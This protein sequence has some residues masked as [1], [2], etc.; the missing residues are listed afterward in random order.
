MAATV[1]EFPLPPREILARN[2]ETRVGKSP[3]LEVISYQ[4]DSPIESLMQSSDLDLLSRRAADELERYIRSPWYS[5]GDE[6]RLNK[7][8][9]SIRLLQ[10]VLELEET[11]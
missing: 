8:R 1:L 5:L 4:V 3:V 10:R 11:L 6:A 2:T 7:L 9:I